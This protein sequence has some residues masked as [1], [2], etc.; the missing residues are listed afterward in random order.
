M[1]HP[2]GFSDEE[3]LTSLEEFRV[4]CGENSPAIVDA[5]AKLVK[6]FRREQVEAGVR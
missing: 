6:N 1:G 5:L 3:L 2:G 4:L